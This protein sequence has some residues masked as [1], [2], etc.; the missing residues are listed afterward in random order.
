MMRS[1]FSAISGLKT[2]QMMLDVTANDIA[3]VNTVGYK[4]TRTTFKDSLSQTAARRRRRRRRRQ[5][6]PNPAQ[7]GLGVRLGVDRHHDGRR[8]AA[9]DRQ[10]RSTSPIQGE[11]WF[12]VGQ[13]HRRPAVPGRSF[14]YTR[15]G[16]FSRN[17]QGYLV[18]AGRL[19]RRRPH[20]S[21]GGGAD[22]LHQH[23][24]DRHQRGDR[25][26]T[27]RSPTCRRPAGGAR[28][29]ARGYISLAKFANEPRPAS[30]PPATAGASAGRRA[31]S[32]VGTPG[33]TTA[34]EPPSAAR[35]RCRTSTSPP[36]SP[37]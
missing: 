37:T 13:A 18:T 23:P 10:R 31:P 27:A 22:T 3:N 1:M 7:V 16:N 20:A 35:S 11:G 25:A 29:T 15:A 14:E 32:D 30:A 36:S 19:L 28:A 24:G 2:H 17:D 6:G 26:R 21:A 8:R 34:S 33:A 4:A 5:G 9:D 12:R